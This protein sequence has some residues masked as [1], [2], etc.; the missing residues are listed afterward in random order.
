MANLVAKSYRLEPPQSEGGFPSC[1]AEMS[2]HYLRELVEQNDRT[3][4]F[5]PD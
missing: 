4:V 2:L 3:G 1:R 5:F